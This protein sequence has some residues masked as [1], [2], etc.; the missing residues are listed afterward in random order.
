MK[1]RFQQ[2]CIL[3]LS[4]SSVNKTGIETQ[5]YSRTLC[6]ILADNI[7]FTLTKVQ[8]CIWEACFMRVF[9]VVTLAF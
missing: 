8:T 5:T 6:K 3:V 2:Y 7:G 9:H 4:A 1:H